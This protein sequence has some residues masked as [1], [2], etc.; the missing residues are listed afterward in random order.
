M[1]KL[2][3]LPLLVA[4]F[5]ITACSEPEP[6][7]EITWGYEGS[8]G[9]QN[10]G[11]YAPT[12][13]NGKMQS[14]IRLTSSGTL[15]ITPTNLLFITQ[16]SENSASIVNSGQMLNIKPNGSN[17][18]TIKRL[19]YQLEN[20]S[21]HTFSEHI[22]DEQSF[23]LEIQLQYRNQH[24]E[25]AIVAVLAEQG[26]SNDTID[27][28]IDGLKSGSMNLDPYTF[29]PESQVNYYHYI[30][31]LTS[32]PCSEDIKWYVMKDRIEVS[33]KQLKV[34]RNLHKQNARPI[35]ATNSRD[36]EMK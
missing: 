29:L 33:S 34:L 25:I 19:K 3:F 14:P 15:S 22:I 18:I 10:W 17:H 28:V 5:M 30:G 13:K 7:K 21:I 16:S 32:P 11:K 31:S 27:D 35:Q 24:D 2:L 4:S 26:G 23:D 36:V 9:P 1:T 8:E 6:V 12:C 20:I